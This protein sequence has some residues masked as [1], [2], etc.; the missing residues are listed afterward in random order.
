MVFSDVFIES[1][2]LSGGQQIVQLPLADL[3]TSFPD[4]QAY[5]KITSGKMVFAS[6]IAP[7]LE[8]EAFASF[9]DLF[10]FIY[11]TLEISIHD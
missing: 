4:L 2:R 8:A 7:N 6:E 3:H 1:I 11:S 5:K 10:T 9:A